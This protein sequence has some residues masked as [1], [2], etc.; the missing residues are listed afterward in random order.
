MIRQTY[1]KCM[2]GDGKS[3][4]GN[5]GDGLVKSIYIYIIYIL[6]TVYIQFTLYTFSINTC[7]VVSKPIKRHD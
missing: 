2:V 1:N 3:G 4:G 5:G 6:H 7:H